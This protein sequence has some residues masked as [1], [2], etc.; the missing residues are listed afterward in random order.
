MRLIIVPQAFKV[1]LPSL[2]N[3]FITL[4]KETAVLSEITISDITRK[5][6]LWASATYLTWEA[7]LGCAIVYLMLTIPLARGV[8]LLERKLNKND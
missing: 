3:E 8:N 2:G 5:S 4:I 6:M 1:V 7:Y